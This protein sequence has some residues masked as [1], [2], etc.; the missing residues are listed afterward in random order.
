MKEVV[1]QQVGLGL[2]RVQ[3]FSFLSDARVQSPSRAER[4]S[5]SSS[6]HRVHSSRPGDGCASFMRPLKAR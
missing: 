4:R 6:Q 2:P 5:A 1:F 3:N